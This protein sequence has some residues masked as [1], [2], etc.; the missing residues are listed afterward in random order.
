[1]NVAGVDGCKAGWFCTIHMDGDLSNN[2]FP[3]VQS[4]YV[5]CVSKGIRLILIDIPIGLLDSGTEERICDQHARS[6][7]KI[8]KS[9]IFPAPC[10]RA[11]HTKNYSEA[12]DINQSKTGR[13]LSRQSFAISSKI[14]EVDLFLMSHTYNPTKCRVREVHPEI[15]FWG[16]NG[17]QEMASAKK[18]KGGIDERLEL[19]RTYW[20][21]AKDFFEETRSLF[22]KKQVADDDIVDSMVCCLTASHHDR[23]R[24]FP[25]LPEVDESGLHME[26]VYSLPVQSPSSKI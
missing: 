21:I 14:A 24:T 10:R 15:C 18:T 9:S 12:C 3:D 20:A 7:L 4:L 8:R 16:L 1:M 11:A 17:E 26:M 6:R 23:L 5:N 22:P 13:R 2:V 19:L 25:P